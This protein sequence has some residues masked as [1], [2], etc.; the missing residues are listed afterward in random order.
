MWAQVRA[1]W[2]GRLR[3][4]PCRVVDP[5]SLLSHSPSPSPPSDFVSASRSRLVAL[6]AQ[7]NLVSDL[8]TSWGKAPL[9]QTRYAPWTATGSTRELLV[10]VL[11]LRLLRARPSAP[12]GLVLLSLPNGG[13][14]KLEECCRR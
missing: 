4:D 10:P 5:L 7:G 3:D 14:V 6:A 1:R 13:N 8:T 9:A 11:D 12:S 2:T